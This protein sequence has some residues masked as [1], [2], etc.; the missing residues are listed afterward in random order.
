M[1]FEKYSQFYID[2]LKST[3]S[4]ADQ[5]AIEV[6]V[7]QLLAHEC[8]FLMGKGRTGLVV[9][10]FAMRLTHLGLRA[11]PLNKPTTPAAGPKDMLLL[12]SGSGETGSIL[13]SA[14]KAKEIGMYVAAIS[15]RAD[16]SLCR[17][18]DHAVVL[19]Q[20]ASLYQGRSASKVLVGTLF[21]QG[22]MMTLECVVGL[23]MEATGQSY[24]DLSARHA[25]IE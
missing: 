14:R 3:L 6:F 20:E 18:A 8:I 10:M 19:R 7:K 21:E 4:G 23:L 2:V 1:S 16:S 15:M 25:N 11:Y 22:L 12:A 9:D 17:L 5:G 13:L 24:E